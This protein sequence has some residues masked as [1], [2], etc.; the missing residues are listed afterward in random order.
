MAARIT[1]TL[2]CYSK[3]IGSTR[4]TTLST[5]AAQ[6]FTINLTYHMPSMPADESIAQQ[7]HNHAFG[8]DGP[9]NSLINEGVFPE[10]W[11][12]KYL[13][14]LETATK[15]WRDQ[16]MWPRELVAAIH[17]ASWHLN[18]R[19][20]SWCSSSGRHNEET[21]CELQSLR[22]PSEIFLMRGSLKS[23]TNAT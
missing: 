12:A 8:D 19:Y 20:D 3:T 23:K 11:A 15:E 16:P 2:C 21:E 14:L 9:T 5:F 13:Q 22:S 6:A 1:W 17:F 7:L 4:E 10:G 18:L